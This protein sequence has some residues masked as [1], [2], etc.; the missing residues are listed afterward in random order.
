MN[1]EELLVMVALRKLKDF[2]TYFWK[3]YYKLV[4]RRNM[5]MSWR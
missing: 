3:E 4:G 2:R 1:V 5:H